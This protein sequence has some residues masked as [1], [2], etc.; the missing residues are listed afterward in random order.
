MMKRFFLVLMVALAVSAASAQDSVIEEIIVRVNNAIITRSDLQRAR[1]QLQSELQQ[2]REARNMADREKDLLRDLIDQQLLVQKAGDLGITGDTEL[3][4][5]LDDIRKSMNLDSMEALERAATQQGVLYEDFKQNLKNSILTQSTIGRE[6]GSKIRITQEETHKYYEEHKQEMQQPERV[7]LSEL[8]VSTETQTADASNG[9]TQDPA[10][11]TAAAEKKAQ[12][13]LQAIKNGLP[14][15]EA[16]K[17]YAP[18]TANPGGDIG[19]FERAPGIESGLGEELEKKTFDQMKAGE[20]SEVIA[21]K[22]GFIILKVTEHEPPSIPEYSEVENRVQEAV[23]VSKLQPALR[24]Y[25]T[26]LREDAFIDIKAGFVDSGASAKQ[27]QPVMASASTAQQ[28]PEPEKKK[29]RFL[30]F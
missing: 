3:I 9:A 26:K 1:R 13:A 20:V 25:L 23:Y 22:Q 18:G 4:K 15:E 2:A 5:R 10:A 30:I 11:L 14:F 27:T 12:E 17:K 8:L 21:T 29:K 28:E 7:R 24:E 16:V 6:V 19:Y